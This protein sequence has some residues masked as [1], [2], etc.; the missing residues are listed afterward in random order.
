[1]NNLR[2]H[3]KNTIHTEIKK[4]RG[5]ILHAEKSIA[6]ILDET[7]L[8]KLKQGI[9]EKNEKIFLLEKRLK[10]VDN[11]E[12]D[13]ELEKSILNNLEETTR[14]HIAT[15][16]RKDQTAEQKR[17]REERAKESIDGLNASNR[18]EKSAERNYRYT[19]RYYDKMCE[20][21][22]EYL[23][24]DLNEKPNNRGFVCRGIHLYGQ[25]S[26]VDDPS[27]IELIE[28][29]SKETLN[30]HIWNDFV[31]EIYSKKHGELPVK[32]YRIE[33]Q[34][35]FKLSGITFFRR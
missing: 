14:K 11:G 10:G 33:R 8:G 25:K 24:K 21:I 17:I 15:Q 34:K 3:E 31:Y 6:S 12:F 13:E 28:R 32:I 30:I 29:I 2:I 16:S 20:F 23:L 26:P 22:P 5:F 35:K 18:E 19:L 4:L 1:M 27:E 7:T 9:V